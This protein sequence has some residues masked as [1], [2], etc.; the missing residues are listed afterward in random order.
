M[1]GKS[2]TGIRQATMNMS[3][4]MEQCIQACTDCHAM[5][6]MALMSIL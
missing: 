2:Q 3:V 1:G 4:E 6:K 5:R